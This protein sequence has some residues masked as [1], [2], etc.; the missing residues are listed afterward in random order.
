MPVLPA[1]FCKQEDMNAYLT[2]FHMPLYDAASQNN[3][4]AIVHLQS[5][6]AQFTA[7]G[8]A[9][10]APGATDRIV[11]VGEE[12]KAYKEQADRHFRI[13][14]EIQALDSRIRVIRI[15]PLSD[16]SRAPWPSPVSVRSVATLATE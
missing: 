16:C 4:D 3:Q 2:S 9:G 7:A 12:L 5:L 15:D 13:A 8:E 10:N 6:N 1:V 14:A 11:K